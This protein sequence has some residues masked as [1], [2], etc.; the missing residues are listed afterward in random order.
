MCISTTFINYHI[1]ICGFHG[2]YKSPIL[3][4]FRPQN[5]WGKIE[6]MIAD[7]I[8]NLCMFSPPYEVAT[9]SKDNGF[10]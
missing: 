1:R 2:R 7:V 6:Y 9:I 3:K 10:D 4:K 8:T 5:L